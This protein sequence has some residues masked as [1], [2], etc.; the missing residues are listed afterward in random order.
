MDDLALLTVPEFCRLLSNEKV[1]LV[2]VFGRDVIMLENRQ[3]YSK[4]SRF[5]W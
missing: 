5:S 1:R 3:Y 2:G 4:L